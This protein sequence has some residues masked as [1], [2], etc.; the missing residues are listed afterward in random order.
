MHHEQDIRK[1][2]GLKKYM[3]ITY[4]CMLIGSLAL[5]GFPGTAGFF[6][7]D[8]IIE[9]VEHSTIP[10]AEFALFC[11]MF[12]VF[13][14][15][16]YSFR[17]FF[18]VFHTE[19]R[20]DDH[21]KEHLKESPW[22]VTVPLIALAIPSLIAGGIGIYPLLF[23]DFFAGAI[24]VAPEHNVLEHMGE[25]YTTWYAFVA[26]AISHPPLYLALAGIGTAYW[27]YVKSPEIP[28]TFMKKLSFL[29]NLMD[30]K[31]YFDIFNDY[32]FAGG[33]RGLGK[34]LWNYGDAK[35]IDGVMVNGSAKSVGWFAG[36]FRHVQSG[37]LYHY[38]FAMIIGV[39]CLVLIFV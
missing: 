4:W 15:A 21:T 2:G 27:F 39:V 38:A 29:Y 24:F 33:A 1:M 32:F 8:G 20:M 28:K 35:L 18:L 23:G 36:V 17:M 10:G 6:S 34:G 31:Y 5:I 16:F 7:K 14:T 26:S 11:V 3:P 9:A 19:E 30:K 25:H 22:V 13:V 37:Y 12:G